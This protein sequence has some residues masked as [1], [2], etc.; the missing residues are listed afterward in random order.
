MKNEDRILEAA[1]MVVEEHTI[2]GTRMHLISERAEMV[3]SNLHY[4]Y[5]T[6]KDLMLA[7]QEKVLDKCLE[8]R[9][10]IRK[11]SEDTLESQ[12]DVFMEQKRA[13]I[14]DYREY[15]YAEVD[16]WVQG[17][18]QPE[19]KKGFAESFAGWR[20]ELGA[21]LDKYV[22]LLPAKQRKYLPYEMVSLLEGATIQ[23]LIDEESFDLDEY[24]AFAK[25]MILDSIKIASSDR[26]EGLA[27]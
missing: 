18:I 17:R 12:L 16:F 7:L 23:Y 24:F 25:K 19:I 20:K 1:L 3:Q 6:K 11:H 14:M 10:S 13:F 8:L 5:K 4:Y 22:P 2:S 21:I 9:E 27:I 15:D 26:E